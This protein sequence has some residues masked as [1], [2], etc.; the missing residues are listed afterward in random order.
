MGGG[1]ETGH[2]IGEDGEAVGVWIHGGSRVPAN[3]PK[4]EEK[5]EKLKIEGSEIGNFDDH[6]GKWERN[7]G[8]CEDDNT[9]C[10]TK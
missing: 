9:I 5:I 10:S 8:N 1:L 7:S 4:G 3:L 6:G 2:D